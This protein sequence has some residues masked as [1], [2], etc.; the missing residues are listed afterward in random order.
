[1]QDAYDSYAAGRGEIEDDV[2]PILVTPQ[3]RCKHFYIAAA[4]ADRL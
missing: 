2:R 4:F 1:M 3:I